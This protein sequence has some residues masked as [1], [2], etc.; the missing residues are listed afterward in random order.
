MA[1]QPAAR[2]T[3]LARG[4][5]LSRIGGGWLAPIGRSRHGHVG[6]PMFVWMTGSGMPE[7]THRGGVR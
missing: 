4:R 1:G 6:W 5:Q 7:V 3:A 2:A